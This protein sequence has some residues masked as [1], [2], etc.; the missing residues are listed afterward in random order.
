MD[1]DALATSVF[2]LGQED[3][4]AMIEELEDVEC[5]IITNDKEIIKSSGFS[6]YENS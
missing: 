6:S 3:G 4:L 5:L 2:I 1:A